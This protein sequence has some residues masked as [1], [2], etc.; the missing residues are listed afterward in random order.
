MVSAPST[1]VDDSL[2]RLSEQL[3]ARHFSV[4]LSIESLR[5]GPDGVDHGQRRVWR[6]PDQGRALEEVT[7]F[8]SALLRLGAARLAEHHVHAG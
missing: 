7:T 1:D 2:R 8:A 5:G 6:G 4:D 3:V